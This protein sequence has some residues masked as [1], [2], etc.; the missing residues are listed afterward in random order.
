MLDSIRSHKTGRR[1]GLRRPDDVDPLLKPVLLD[2]LLTTCGF[3]AMVA[4]VVLT[5]EGLSLN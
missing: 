2:L 4:A 5:V 1:L 3:V